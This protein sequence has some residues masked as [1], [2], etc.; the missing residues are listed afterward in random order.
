MERVFRF[1]GLGGRALHARPPCPLKPPTPAKNMRGSPRMIL[2]GK[3]ILSGAQ[4]SR[5]I[6]FSLHAEDMPPKMEC[7]PFVEGTRPPTPMLVDR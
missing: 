3:R 5:R 4:R 7:T 6:P 2:P 1:R